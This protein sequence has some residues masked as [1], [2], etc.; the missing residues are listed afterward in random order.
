[1]DMNITYIDETA[2]MDESTDELQRK[3]LMEK[4]IVTNGLSMN[5]KDDN[6]HHE[7]D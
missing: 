7:V 5:V 4:I 2:L 3:F 6:G 1:M